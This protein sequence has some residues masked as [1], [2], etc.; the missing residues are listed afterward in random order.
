[1]SGTTDSS[2]EIGEEL[3]PGL[4]S[5]ASAPDRTPQVL[6]WLATG[7]IL[8][9]TAI[10]VAACAVRNSWEH[11]F[12]VLPATGPPWGLSLHVSIALVTV[13]M[14]LAALLAGGG[15]LAGLAALKR[16]GRLPIR[17]LLSA[18]IAAAALFTVLPPTGSTDALDY[19]A[20]GRMVVLGHS[21]YVMTPK[22]LFRSGD[23]IGRDV[24]HDWRK[25]VTVY[26]P[27]ATA[28]QYA[29]AALGGLSAAR[30]IFWLKLWNLLAFGAL[31][32][33]LDRL[34]RYDPARRA[35]GHLLWTANPL[36]LWI[37]V[38]AGHIDLLAGAFGFFGLLML[39]K[40]EPADPE[41]GAL[42][43][44]AAGLLVGVA[45][46]LKISYVLFGLGL[47]WAARRSLATW[48]SAAA[49]GAIVLLPTYLWFGPPAAKAL[50]AR[51]GQASV[52]SFYQ[53][54]VGSYGKILPHQLL[55]AGVAFIGIAA[56]ML[57]RF[58]EGA[59]GL[60]AVRPALALSVAWL[61]VWPYQLPWYDTM[62][63]CLIVLYPASRLDWLVVVRMTAATFALMPGNAGYPRQHLLKVITSDSL[64]YLA[65]AVLLAAAV[66]LVWLCRTGR[67]D[68]GPVFK[69]REA[70]VPLLV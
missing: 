34:L 4:V 52:D 5:T 44:L 68:M 40:R 3:I 21:P 11:P 31:A 67:W 1:M 15:V 20:Y 22:Q 28:E 37:L 48:F 19:A 53:L 63:I 60:P 38:A 8:V 42:R 58:P 54:F 17:L 59:P 50:I 10:M 29:A 64:Y 56:L 36:L 18:G 61:F 45:A 32:L 26:G 65:P 69:P 46:D 13:A 24:P 14:W 6:G 9:S 2:Q 35:R 12:I 25:H 27:L 57:W 66:A 43:G 23:P 47:A 49:G 41:P 30:I 16:G 33:A 55:V 7:S 39:R 70:E 51:D 62:V